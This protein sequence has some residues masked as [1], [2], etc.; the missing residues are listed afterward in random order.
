MYEKLQVGGS[1]IPVRGINA[2]IEAAD[3]DKPKG[4]VTA[5][6]GLR[7]FG[8]GIVLVRNLTGSQRA[9][10][11]VVGLG[12]A[13][14]LPSSDLNEFLARPIGFQSAASAPDA[15]THASRFAILQDPAFAEDIV[16]A[17]TSGLT[18]VRIDITDEDHD[19]AEVRD[20]DS[21]QLRSSTSGPCVIL[22]KES[23]TGTKWALV[24][25]DQAGELVPFEL[26]GNL[27]QFGA[28]VQAWKCE[29][30]DPAAN[31]WTR[32]EE[33]T[34]ITPAGEWHGVG[35]GTAGNDGENWGDV[36][37]CRKV[38]DVWCA[39]GSGW[40]SLSG[41]V[42]SAEGIDLS[43][44]GNATITIPQGEERAAGTRE[45]TITVTAEWQDL[46]NTESIAILWTDEWKGV[47][48]REPT[49]ECGLIETSPGSGEWKVDAE[50]LAGYG[51]E[52]DPFGSCTINWSCGI[53]QEELVGSGENGIIEG[54]FGCEIA[55][56]CDYVNEC[57]TTTRVTQQLLVAA[58]CGLDGQVDPTPAVWVVADDLAGRGLV[59]SGVT[60]CELEASIGDGLE[61]GPSD[62]IQA[63]LGCELEFDETGATRLA[64]ND[65][66]GDGLTVDVSGA[67]PQF[68]IDNGCNLG[69]DELGRLEH[70]PV[71]GP[72]LKAYETEGGC[73]GY[74]I[75]CD[76]IKANC[77]LGL[78]GVAIFM[79][80]WQGVAPE[81]VAAEIAFGSIVA[82]IYAAAFA[83]E[84]SINPAREEEII[85]SDNVATNSNTA[86]IEDAAGVA[87][88][89]ERIAAWTNPSNASGESDDTFAT[90]D[91]VG[92]DGD[93]DPLSGDCEDGV[94]TQILRFRF[95]LGFAQPPA[96]KQI[97][98]SFDFEIHCDTED[99]VSG[100]ME[101]TSF[102]DCSA[103]VVHD[104][105][106]IAHG[107]EASGIPGGSINLPLDFTSFVIDEN[108]YD[109]PLYLDLVWYGFPWSGTE[110]RVPND[111]TMFLDAVHLEISS[112]CEEDIPE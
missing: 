1:R 20:G 92:A 9:R 18:Q 70:Q 21:T 43:A 52:A 13:L 62:V 41:V 101:G 58:G 106:T 59:A 24:R 47:K 112:T 65:L 40:T 6:G 98:V 5:D 26:Q 37:L 31:T 27:M 7:H 87:L 34:E 61:F 32:A 69:L 54:P 19:H 10:F 4:G 90:V 86:D 45:F 71:I 80:A 81:A 29:S 76:W 88:T 102:L 79:A 72:G 28:A 16:Q 44:T 108:N 33:T 64:M 105:V 95:P 42:D 99:A 14:V 53:A 35:F 50:T 55:V 68:K 104:G 22:W 46:P 48:F 67:C 51:L 94:V 39:V 38:G 100:Y 93:P 56:D 89:T 17:V 84:T 63:K 75:D 73:P 109:E 103:R 66:A 85:F 36:V 83:A 12:D 107:G 110:C 97:T 3:R 8:D 82:P 25:I 23:G 111:H 30:Y 60:I 49:F 74:Q 11:D 78:A 15:M 96:G 57:V 2:A 77:A 91:I